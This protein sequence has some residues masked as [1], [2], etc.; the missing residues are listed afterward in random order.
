MAVGRLLVLGL[1]PV[2]MGVPAVPKNYRIRTR[3]D[4]RANALWNPPPRLRV[5]KEDTEKN[6]VN[7][8][9]LRVS[10]VL[11]SHVGEVARSSAALALALC[12]AGPGFPSVRS[13]RYQVVLRECI[14]PGVLPTKEARLP[15]RP[16]RRASAHD[17]T[18]SFRGISLRNRKPAQTNDP[19]RT[20]RGTRASGHIR[21]TTLSRTRGLA[22]LVVDQCA[23][24]GGGST[25]LPPGL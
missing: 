10:V 1:C 15:R 21:E 22:E 11:S 23:S 7:S 19:S 4:L 2:V 5:C 18:P 8:P 12:R 17:G 3:P 20:R 13:Y 16:P 24:P 6:S 25:M 9:C 14:S